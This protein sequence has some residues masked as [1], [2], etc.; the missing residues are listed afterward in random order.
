[1]D[2]NTKNKKRME[3]AFAIVSILVIASM[4]L[5]YMPGLFR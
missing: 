1:M 2:F 5:L 3:R 4:I